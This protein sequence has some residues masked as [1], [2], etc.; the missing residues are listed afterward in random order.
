MSE[1]PE[2]SEA[3]EAFVND[4]NQLLKTPVRFSGYQYPRAEVKD[5]EITR[6]RLPEQKLK[7]LP[8]N[9]S[10]STGFL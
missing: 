6:L 2:L 1:V 3:S 7:R 9:S 8:P 10:T 5:G 4:L